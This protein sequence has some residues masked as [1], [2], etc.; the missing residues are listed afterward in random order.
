M[1]ML[2]PRTPARLA[3]P[4]R[5][6]R[7]RKAAELESRTRRAGEQ[8]AG[9][10]ARPGAQVLQDLSAAPG[11]LTHAEAALRLERHG[12]NVV[13]HERAPRWWVRLAKAFRNPFIAVLVFLAAVMWWQDP[14]DPGV[15]ILSVMVGVSGLLRFWQEF[16]SGRAADAL[17]ELVT[18]TCAVQR[19]AGSARGL[20]P[21]RCPWTRWSRAMW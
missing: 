5:G 13:A 12:A 15:V 4:G 18:T 8:L 9:F 2:T 11:G 3:P 14:A 19:R 17:K 21:S 1:T 16:R 20:P 6:R 10:S 7:E